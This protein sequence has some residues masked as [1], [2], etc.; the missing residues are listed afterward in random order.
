MPL[1]SLGAADCQYFFPPERSQRCF[2]QSVFFFLFRYFLNFSFYN[3]CT[4]Q[5]MRF[6]FC[7]PIP[8]K[9]RNKCKRSNADV[10]REVWQILSDKA[11][12]VG[13]EGFD[14]ACCN[15]TVVFFWRVCLLLEM[16]LVPYLRLRNV[17]TPNILHHLLS[18][19]PSSPSPHAPFPHPTQILVTWSAR[20]MLSTSLKLLCSVRR[21]KKIQLRKSG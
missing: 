6:F 11:S 14:V 7:P 19:H 12:C 4:D 21:K 13:F 16:K 1:D 2:E 3:A 9:N 8:N 15:A 5:N 10:S 17:A 20:D 18:P